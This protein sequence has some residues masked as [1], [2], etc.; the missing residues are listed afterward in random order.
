MRRSR[1]RIQAIVDCVIGKDLPDCF[2]FGVDVRPID[3]LHRSTQKNGFAQPFPQ[4]RCLPVAAI[5]LQSGDLA[6][7]ILR[8]PAHI[9]TSVTGFR[10]LILRWLRSV[11]RLLYFKPPTSSSLMGERYF[12][13]WKRPSTGR[14]FLAKEAMLRSFA[15]NCLKRSG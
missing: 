14:F 12:A 2:R 9:A 13:F 3:S 1:P 11:P 15:K 10:A 8:R 6:A 4:R 5:H 7:S